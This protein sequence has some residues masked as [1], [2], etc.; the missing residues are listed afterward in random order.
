MLVPRPSHTNVIGTKWIFKNKTDEFCNMVRNK[1]RLIA[2]YY[3]QIQ[4]ID[5]DE[6][7]ALIG[8]LQYIRLLFV[9]A[10]LIDFNLFQMDVESTFFS[11]VLNEEAYVKQPKGFNPHFPNHVFKLKKNL[12]D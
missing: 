3:T 8:R 12:Y 10:C 2:Q 6:T 5:F 4:R 9:V 11:G 7:F 1:A